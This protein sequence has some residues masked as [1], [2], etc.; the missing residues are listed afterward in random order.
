MSRPLRIEYPGAFYH[1][2][3]RGNDKKEIYRT[4]VDY[5]LFLSILKDCADRFD[6]LVH[7]Y[8]LIPSHFHLLIETKDSNLSEFTKRLL[9][10]YTIRFNRRHHRSG[11]L[12]QGRYKALLVDKDNYFLELSRYIHLN[13]TK[14]KLCQNPEDFPWSSMKYFL[15]DKA[16]DLIHREF[17][18]KSFK[19]KAEYHQFVMDGVNLK[20][21][22]TKNALGGLLVGSEDFLKK[23]KKQIKKKKT[24]EFRGKRD[25]FRAPVDQ[26]IKHLENTDQ[27]LVIYAL[28]KFSRANQRQIGERFNISHS[29]VSVS[30]KRFESLLTKDKLLKNQL[31]KL[32]QLT[33]MSNV[34]D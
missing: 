24:L 3:S 15:K 1:I 14:A 28:W 16:P 18:L 23:L 31:D 26:V 6:V 27:R 8:C 34:E 17:T 11:H 13:P 20:I 33:Q 7:A 9:G 22:P 2:F 21:D 10:L 29:A 12:F 19:S 5:E 25:L 4:D 32:Q 30:I